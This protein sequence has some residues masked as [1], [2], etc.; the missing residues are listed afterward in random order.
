MARQQYNDGQ[1]IV[2]EDLNR[3]QARAEQELYDRII[4]ELVQKTED[5]FFSDG[6]LTSFA[7]PTSVSVNGGIGFQT[8][9]TVASSEPQKR[10]LYLP[11]AK[12]VNLQAPDAALNR[13]D[14]IAVK[15]N[16][17]NG[18]IENRKFK[19]AGTL[20]I[21][22]QPLVVSNEWEAEV[23]VVD[24]T[25][26]ASPV[27]PAVPSGYIKI[28]ECFVNAVTGMIGAGDVTDA[29]SLMP[30]GGE[31]DVNTLAFQRVTQD[32]ALNLKQVLAELDAN[33]VL[34]RL[35]SN[36]FND[37][38]T[39]APAPGTSGQR[40]LYNKG[41]ILFIRES[42]PEGSAVLPVGSGAGGGGGGA[43][44][45]GDAL[46]DFEYDEKVW[47]FTQGSSQTLDLYIKVP[48]GYLAGRPISAF[49][50]FYSPS[51][52]LDFKMQLKS[53]LIRKNLDAIN[54]VANTLTDN[55]GDLTNTLSYMYRESEIQVT[56]G[57]GTI[58]SFA[59]SPG[60]LI[61]LELSRIAP[62]GSEDTAEIRFVPSST[63]VKF[64]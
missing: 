42:I 7:S 58:N 29:R 41:G 25:P 15:H 3:Q 18:A 57:A 38:G 55:T 36:T 51:N 13:I 53:T 37:L 59:V 62:T 32:P 24:G 48:Q 9:A 44:W 40:I 49:L 1:E 26:S 61:R 27:A 52:S 28:A 33:Q 17:I 21:S 16:R 14:S 12:T 63:E 39:D 54:T 35:N 34:G 45:Q 8:D 60:D 19:D 20:V 30:I 5:A 47:K 22:T 64:G 56:D 46:E 23:L 11:T 6:F 4:F 31:I 43:N 2:F 10:L 50:G